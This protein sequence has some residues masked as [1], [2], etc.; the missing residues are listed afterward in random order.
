MRWWLAAVF[1]AIATLTAVLIAA[2]SSRQADR[3]LRANAENIALGAAISA[4]SAVEQALINGN[5]AEQLPSIG[6][7]HNLALFVFSPKRRLLAQGRYRNVHWQDVP[8][9]GAAVLTALGE[10][11]YVAT[12]AGGRSTLVA[13][14]L[15]R[16]GGATVLVAYAPRPPY[17]PSLAIFRHDVV[18]ASVYAV[19]IAAL[20]GLV[21]ATLIARRLRRIASAAAAIEQG[22]FALELEPSLHDEIGDLAVTID[23][24]RRHLGTAF[25]QLSAERDRLERLLEQFHEGVLAID[26]ELRIQ[27][28]NANARLLLAGVSLEKGSPLPETHGG[29]PLR[30]VAEGLFVPGAPVAEAR[31]RREDGA[32]ISLVGVPA[33]ASDLVVLV[34][35][36]IT[37]QE[38]RRQAEREFVANASHE[39]RTPVTAI[40]SAVEALKSGAEDS[41]ESR[42][43]FIDLIGRQ[44]NRLTRL[45]SSLL[46]LARAQTRQEDVQLEPVEL[47][48]LLREIAAAS[49]PTDG[50]AVR[51]DCPQPVVAVGQRD[52]V[53][54]VVSNLVGN[55]LKHTVE[56]EVVLRARQVAE[57][58]AIE[59]A[60]TGPGISPAVQTR[61][62]DRFYSLDV[63]GRGGFGLGLAIARDS[64]EA[65]GGTL[66]IDSEPGHGTTAR[67]VLPVAR[68][69]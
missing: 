65:I 28:A 5:L 56:G 59:I 37:E 11:R 1:V 7:R 68:R 23:R 24:M 54:Q 3:E 29:L 6:A 58:A 50:V 21:A 48:G 2:V 69:G 25:E 27:F 38:R 14:P 49:E 32:T 45:S 12:F 51:V 13:L 55:A 35:A 17:G 22:D 16:K 66:T 44:A 52:I 60:D 15:D 8:D 4:R 9:G 64:A 30:R 63:N 46:I 41:P 36:D 42:R 43:R 10:G 31:S 33:S 39:L 57:G 47:R 18:Q 61:M 20:T 62:F 19:L 53:E 26:R 67:V 34:F 40:A